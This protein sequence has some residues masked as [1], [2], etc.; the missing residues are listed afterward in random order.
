MVT[1]FGSQ[2]E[3]QSLEANVKSES[4]Q[5]LSDVSELDETPLWW[6]LLPLS[7][8]PILL[9]VP[10]IITSLG[11]VMALGELEGGLV[12]FSPGDQNW[13]WSLVQFWWVFII[14]HGAVFTPILNLLGV[15]MGLLVTLV[16]WCGYLEEW[17]HFLCGGLSMRPAKGC[18]TRGLPTRG[19]FSR[20]GIERGGVSAHKWEY[21][22]EPRPMRSPAGVQQW[23]WE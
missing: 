13:A 8:S 10:I 11:L 19:T 23:S 6:V 9:E 16:T 18:P 2:Q 14:L 12:D 4:T 1:S 22:G 7:W 15:T 20:G 17:S 3:R 21:M 5:F